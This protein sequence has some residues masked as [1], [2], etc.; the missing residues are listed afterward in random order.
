MAGWCWVSPR[1]TLFVGT[2][3]TRS[4][5]DR[6]VRKSSTALA[7]IVFALGQVGFMTRLILPVA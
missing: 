7:G 1:L 5:Q 4:V 2:V 6:L 3:A